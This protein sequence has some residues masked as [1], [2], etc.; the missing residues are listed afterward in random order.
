M[1]VYLYDGTL[2]SDKKEWPFN[3]MDDVQVESSGISE[4]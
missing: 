2:L 4:E 3:D 1:V